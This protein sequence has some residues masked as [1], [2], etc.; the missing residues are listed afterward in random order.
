MPDT[1]PSLYTGSRYG[2][3]GNAN[4]PKMETE[5]VGFHISFPLKC[6]EMLERDG[7]G[8]GGSRYTFVFADLYFSST[9]QFINKKVTWTHGFIP[10]LKSRFSR[11]L[12]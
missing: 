3:Y 9:P 11:I 6:T 10:S 5:R 2:A 4:P 8:R 1:D 12:Q 7:N